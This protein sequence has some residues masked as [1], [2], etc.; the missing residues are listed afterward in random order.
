MGLPD[1][2]PL[3]RW[4]ASAGLD[5]ADDVAHLVVDVDLLLLRLPKRLGRT[6]R[7][8]APSAGLGVHLTAYGQGG[9]SIRRP[10]LKGIEGELLRRVGVASQD[11][12]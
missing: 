5:V 11:I 7:R 12:W 1:N 6:G 8:R 10:K 3:P 2:P 9:I 4:Q